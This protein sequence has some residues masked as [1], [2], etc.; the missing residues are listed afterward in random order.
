M[1]QVMIS[2]HAGEAGWPKPSGEGGDGF[3]PRLGVR[4]CPSRTSTSCAPQ[5]LMCLQLLG[6]CLLWTIMPAAGS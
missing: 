3:A 5:Q 4:E 2:Y 6:W 1:A